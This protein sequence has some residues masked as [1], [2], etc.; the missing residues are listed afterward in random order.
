MLISSVFSWTFKRYCSILP[1]VIS[2]LEL[3]CKAM[4]VHTDNFLEKTVSEESFHKYL[5]NLIGCRN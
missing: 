2:D 4:P 1:V 5:T 3:Y